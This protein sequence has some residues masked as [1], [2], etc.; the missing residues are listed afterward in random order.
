MEK[1]YAES[2]LLE[3]LY[4][5]DPECKVADLVTGAVA[6]LG[7]NIIVNRFTRYAIGESSL[8]GQPQ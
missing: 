4:I 3:Q 7:E 1:F 2:C 6:T 8:N 5:K